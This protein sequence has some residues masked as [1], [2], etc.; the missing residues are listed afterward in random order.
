MY[1]LDGGSFL[2]E[3][4]LM[5]FGRAFGKA[6]RIQTAF[7]AF[8]T[9]EGWVLYDTGWHPDAAVTLASYGQEPRMGEENSVAGQLG[10]IGVTPSQVAMVVLSH[11]HLDHA[12]GLCFFPGCTSC[13]QKDEFAYA[14]H[15]NSFQVH[16]YDRTAFDIP[17]LVWKL[18]EGD[19]VLFPG[20]TV[21]LGSGHTPGLQAL[22]VELPESGFYILGSDSAFL[23]ENIEKEIPPGSAWDPV[24]A[25]YSIK[26]FKALRA[27]LDARHFPGHDHDFFTGEVQ[28]GQAMT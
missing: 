8:D 17:S 25:H 5:K 28:M 13:V 24:A 10:K 7:Y 20:L 9:E 6:K 3:S 15:P 4:S 19:T 14:H 12:G 1:V 16:H 11:L 27:L 2:L 22:V 21:M 26:R 18:L 23:K